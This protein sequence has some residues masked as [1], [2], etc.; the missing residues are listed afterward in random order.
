MK[1]KIRTFSGGR[2]GFKTI[3]LNR[4]KG[5]RER[6]LNCSGWVYKEVEFCTFKDCEL[7]PYRMGTGE[8]D[9]NTRSID[10][11][12]YCLWCCCDQSNE[13]NKCVSSEC[14]LFPYRLSH[15]DRTHEL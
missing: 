10:I 1:Y 6:C 13:V 5:I 3:N 11:R 2:S 9:A 8:Q 7:Y 15:T 4:R 14:S 12:K